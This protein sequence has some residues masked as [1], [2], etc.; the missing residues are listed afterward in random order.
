MPIGYGADMFYDDGMTYGD[1]GGFGDV[2]GGYPMT[3][4]CLDCQNSSQSMGQWSSGMQAI[5]ETQYVPNHYAP[6]QPVPTPSQSRPAPAPAAQPGPMPAPGE[7]GNPIEQM[8]YLAP[9]AY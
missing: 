1:Y 4:G 7:P 6:S 9:P 2:Y 8:G 5:P 3:S